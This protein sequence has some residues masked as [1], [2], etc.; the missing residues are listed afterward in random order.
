MKKLFILL[1]F[2]SPAFGQE[3]CKSKVQ[4][5]F[6]KDI[7]TI[8]LC[9]QN[10]E[11]YNEIFYSQFSIELEYQISAS[12]NFLTN[13][14]IEEMESHYELTEEEKEFYKNKLHII[15]PSIK[16]GDRIK[17]HYTYKEGVKLYYN[18]N[19]IGEIADSTFAYRFANIWIHPNAKFNDTR[20]F[21]FL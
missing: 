2:F 21:L 3:M 14:S 12:K 15:F 19:F 13:S 1:L 17:L 9:K 18:N 4:T 5:Y 11:S 10:N 6:F 20:N 7:Y 8:T 16:K